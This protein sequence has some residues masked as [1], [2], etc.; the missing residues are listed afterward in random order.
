MIIVEGAVS[1]Q[2]GL[3]RI[4]S[5]RKDKWKFFECNENLLY[6]CYAENYSANFIGKSTRLQ[7]RFSGNHS[8]SYAT[9]NIVNGNKNHYTE[10][11][12]AL[13]PET[14]RSKAGTTRTKSKIIQQWR[15]ET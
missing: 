12:V 7:Q 15:A 14:A 3:K 13:A 8:F 4:I 11:H 9:Q 6:M 10:L 1:L 5:L 2:D